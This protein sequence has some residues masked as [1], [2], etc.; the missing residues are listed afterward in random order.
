M[1]PAKL[2]LIELGHTHNLEGGLRSPFPSLPVASG[3]SMRSLF[4]VDAV[5]A[6][7]FPTQRVNPVAFVT[8]FQRVNLCVN[9]HSA[10]RLIV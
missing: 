3:Q 8:A 5:P 2:T 10:D 9:L 7:R 6:F 4:P 1:K